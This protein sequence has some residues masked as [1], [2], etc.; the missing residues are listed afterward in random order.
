M[1]AE[2]HLPGSHCGRDYRTKPGRTYAY[3]SP[4]IQRS[5]LSTEDLRK[6]LEATREVEPWF[7]KAMLIALLSAQRREDITR[8]KFSDVKDG[9]LFITQGKKGNTLAIPFAL[10]L[11][12]IDMTP[13]DGIALCRRDNPSEYLIYSATRRH[14]RKPGPVSPENITQAFSRA[15]ALWPGHNRESADLSRHKKSVRTPV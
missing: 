8:M 5:R 1:C 11:P 9:R 10:G 13:I 3:I 12:E 15:R 7:Y 14:G 2:R 6:L 4:K